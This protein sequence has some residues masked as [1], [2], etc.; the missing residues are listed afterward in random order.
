MWLQS[1]TQAKEDHIE[2]CKASANALKR[3]QSLRF[4]ISWPLHSL[5]KKCLKGAKAKIEKKKKA[6]AKSTENGEENEEDQYNAEWDELDQEEWNYIFHAENRSYI[7]NYIQ[8]MYRVRQPYNASSRFGIIVTLKS[9][10]QCC[11]VKLQ[12]PESEWDQ[13]EWAWLDSCFAGISHSHSISNA[14]NASGSCHTERYVAGGLPICL[15]TCTW[16]ALQG[17]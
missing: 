11:L 5:Q 4:S 2:S 3:R 17:S 8:A 13:E 9:K 12:D 7:C 14:G 15:G 1:I 10:L 6:K 16:A